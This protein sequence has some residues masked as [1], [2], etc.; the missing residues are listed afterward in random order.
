MDVLADFD[1]DSASAAKEQPGR[2]PVPAKRT[3]A[4]SIKGPVPV[5]EELYV[6]ETSLP[7][8]SPMQ[9]C[10]PAKSTES[11]PQ[12]MV[13]AERTMQTGPG[14]PVKP[15]SSPSPT[16]LARTMS[17]FSVNTVDGKALYY[18]QSL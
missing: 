3:A 5:Q 7:P 4:G 6:E 2:V 11:T 9:L 8:G 18:C 17:R 12:D 16:K 1:F 13:M 10:S 14:Q 15:I